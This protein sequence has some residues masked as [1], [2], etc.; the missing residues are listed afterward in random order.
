MTKDSVAAVLERLSRLYPKNID[1]S[2][3][4]MFELLKKLGNPQDDLPPVIHIAGTNGKGSTLA[5]IRAFLEKSG[6]SAHV[7]TSPHLVKFNERIV[8]GGKQI[9]DKQLLDCLLQ[10]E[11]ANDGAPL[12]FFEAT[13]AAA[14]LAFSAY[15]ADFVL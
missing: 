15:P 12:T 4:R 7:Y 11:D 2:L 5:F 14:F 13:T 10:V 6:K 8:I 9:S 1:L 3:D